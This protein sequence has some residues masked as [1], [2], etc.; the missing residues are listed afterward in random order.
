MIEIKELQAPDK[1]TKNSEI[2]E[3]SKQEASK[4]NG[5]FYYNLGEN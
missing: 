4:V 5:G 2:T 3:I 1:T